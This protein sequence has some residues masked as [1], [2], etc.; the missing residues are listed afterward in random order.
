[1]L[2]FNSSL[3]GLGSVLQSKKENSGAKRA[4]WFPYDLLRQHACLNGMFDI[5][6][7]ANELVSAQKTNSLT[8]IDLVLLQSA[9]KQS[10]P[11]ALK[12]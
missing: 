5:D 11:L 9:A 3:S 1:M 6:L 8:T 10:T 2:L 7:Y 12:F 4:H